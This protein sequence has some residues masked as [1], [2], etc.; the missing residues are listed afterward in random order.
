MLFKHNFVHTDCHAGNILVKIKDNPN[1][2]MTKVNDFLVKAKNYLIAQVIKYGFDSEYLQNL[3]QQNYEYEKDVQSL[4]DKFK[5]RAEIV[6]IDVGMAM[7][8]T[9]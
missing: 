3:S 1:E 7:K 4:V 8:L 9:R 2:F 6:L 5:E